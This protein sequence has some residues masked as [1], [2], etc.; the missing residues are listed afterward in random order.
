MLVRTQT[1]HFDGEEGRT[2][3]ENVT[4]Y[5]KVA[6]GVEWGFSTYLS[7]ND[8]PYPLTGYTARAQV[9][10]H[11]RSTGDPLLTITCTVSVALG[12][13]IMTLTEEQVAE[14]AGLSGVYD[15][16]LVDASGVCVARLLE[17][18]FMIDYEVTR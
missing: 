17:G 2:T 8:E 7:E 18:R 12:A 9:R 4:H 1:V 15:L 16:E 11:R 14:N 13:V 5:P 3:D 6:A 10:A